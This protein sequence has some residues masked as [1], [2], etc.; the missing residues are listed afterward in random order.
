MLVLSNDCNLAEALVL[1]E[2]AGV[3]AGRI[4]AALGAGYAASNGSQRLYPRLVARD[5]TRAMPSRLSKTS[6]WCTAWPR[7]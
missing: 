1:A 7:S 5:F 4:P 2:A 3:D 6:T